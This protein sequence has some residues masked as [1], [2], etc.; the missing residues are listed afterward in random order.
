VSL[1]ERPLLPPE[2]HPRDRPR[3]YVVGSPEVKDDAA[4]ISLEWNIGQWGRVVRERRNVQT[5]DGTKLPPMY[6]LEPTHGFFRPSFAL[7]SPLLRLIV[8]VVS[9]ND[10]KKQWCEEMRPEHRYTDYG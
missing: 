2:M 8:F 4:S 3:L 9:Q 6:T 7:S 5:V 1:F 10:E